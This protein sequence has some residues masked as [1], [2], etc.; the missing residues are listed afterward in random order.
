MKIR[1]LAAESLGVRG[2][3][4][5]IELGKR[6]IIIDPGLALGYCRNKLM[7]HPVQ[8]GVGEI[9]RNNII[10]ELKDATDIVISHLHGDHIPL[11]DANAYQLSLCQIKYIAPTCRIWINH[12]GSSSDMEKTREK[13]LV[14]GLNISSNEA[15]G[16]IDEILSFLGPVPHGEQSSPLGKVIMT[17]VNDTSKSFLHASDTQLFSSHTVDKIIQSRSNIVLASGPPLYLIKN[18]KSKIKLV[19][20]NSL[21]LARN[22]DTLIL[23]HH[24]LRSNEGLNW[25]EKLRTL[26]GKEVISAADFMNCK[27][28]LLEANR[29]KL[30]K[31]IPVI[32]N[33]HKLY[34]ENQVTSEEYMNLAREKYSW[35]EY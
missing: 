4:C 14:S 27:N 29:S 7:P 2:L 19:W 35:F 20:E 30:Y 23:D 11:F 33:W 21:K 22:I 6:K 34:E 18:M 9:I 5:V 28:H 1:I 8:V 16:Q 26:S 17:R 12:E 31:D 10:Q 15:S 13:F 3:G 32:K 24:L 25:I